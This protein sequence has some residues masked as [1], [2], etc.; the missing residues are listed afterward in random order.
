[1]TEEQ[2]KGKFSTL[3]EK[4]ITIERSLFSLKKDSEVIQ[5]TL[6]SSAIEIKNKLVDLEDHSKR[7][8][9][10]TN[11]IKESSNETWEE[12]EGRVN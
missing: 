6:P 12:C 3:N 4:I 9:L 2:T 1:M 10:R 11:G 7:N 5:T 8:N